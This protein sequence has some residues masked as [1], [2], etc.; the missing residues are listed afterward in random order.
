[1]ERG[2]TK[3]LS[4]IDRFLTVWIFAAMA[5]GVG[6]GYFLPGIAFFHRRSGI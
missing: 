3:K 5:V 6:S 4:F 1:M 2:V